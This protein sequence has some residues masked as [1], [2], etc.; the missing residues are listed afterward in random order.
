MKLFNRVSR[1]ILSRGRKRPVNP[2]FELVEDRV[3]LATFTVN[4]AA[5]PFGR[6]GTTTLRQAI[7]DSNATPGPNTIDFNISGPGVHTINLASPLPPITDP[8]TIDGTSQGGYAGTPLITLTPSTTTG[9]AAVFAG[10][11]LDIYAG[12]TT[13]QGLDIRGFNGDGIL[14]A[15]NGNNTIQNN[16]IG[17]DAAGSAPAAN[18]GNGL[19]IQG[20]PNNFVHDNLI[21]GNQQNGV[22]VSNDNTTALL[23]QTIFVSAPNTSS[24]FINRRTQTHLTCTQPRSPSV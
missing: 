20:S 2:S 18:T 13:V 3:L 7:D 17:T 24:N 19:A 5:D 8:V 10:D 14:L 4:S 6:E 11:G 21:S 23:T 15:A 1:R 12:G 16:Y 22:S 9:G